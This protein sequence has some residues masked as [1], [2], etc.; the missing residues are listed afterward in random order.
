[1]PMRSA[2]AA[3][4]PRIWASAALKVEAADGCEMDFSKFLSNGMRASGL[5]DSCV[6][7]I[8]RSL[9]GGATGLATTTAAATNATPVVRIGPIAFRT[10]SPPAVSGPA[11]GHST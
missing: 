10:P 8:C 2:S 11:S 6:V 1:M 3:K 4:A 7:E 9:T 5:V